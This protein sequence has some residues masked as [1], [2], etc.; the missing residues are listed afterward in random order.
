MKDAPINLS[1]LK[2]LLSYDPDTGVFIWKVSR[3]KVKIGDAAGAPDSEGYI[4]IGVAGNSYR[5]GRLAWFYV[6]GVW[7]KELIDHINQDKSDDRLV[8]LREATKKENQRNK[9]K[10]KNN[11]SGYKGVSWNCDNKCWQAAIAHGAGKIALGYFKT[12][13]RA[14]E[15]YCEAAKKLHGEFACL[16]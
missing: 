3:G 6:H 8:N 7:P 4:K 11:K 14:Y 1:R 15:A 10:Y 12:K 2:E 5:R 13:E 9:R 16:T